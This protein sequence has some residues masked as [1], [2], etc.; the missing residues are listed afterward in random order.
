MHSSRSTF[1]GAG[2][3]RPLHIGISLLMILRTSPNTR[4]FRSCGDGPM[5]RC[6][7]CAKW[8]S[9]TN[10]ER[11]K[12]ICGGVE[13]RLRFGGVGAAQQRTLHHPRCARL[14]LRYPRYAA[15]RGHS[16]G[17]GIGDVAAFV[18]FCSGREDKKAGGYREDEKTNRFPHS[19]SCRPIARCSCGR[20][21][22]VRCSPHS[23]KKSCHGRKQR[24]VKSC[25][26]TS[27][28][29]FPYNR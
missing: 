26:A 16:L 17:G 13:R 11:R 2:A 28:N 1:P 24:R 27:G 15:P 7:P 6:V 25:I 19:P 22:S 14:F 29:H 18:A 23:Q 12:R 5:T 3:D 20:V 8:R 21:T 10:N 9:G 4:P